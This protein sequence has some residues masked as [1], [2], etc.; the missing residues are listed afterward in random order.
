MTPSTAIKSLTVISLPTLCSGHS[1]W[2]E[3]LVAGLGFE[4]WIGDPA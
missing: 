1:R 3:P 2:F 4:L